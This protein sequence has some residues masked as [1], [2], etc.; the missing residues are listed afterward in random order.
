MLMVHIQARTTVFFK[1]RLV[2]LSSTSNIEDSLNFTPSAKL[3][4]D[5]VLIDLQRGKTLTLL[6]RSS[7]LTSPNTDKKKREQ[8]KDVEDVAFAI[9]YKQILQWDPKF[10][11]CSNFQRIT[12]IFCVAMCG[13]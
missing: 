4:C 11:L 2:S 12:A 1:E 9:F 7:L 8:I 6:F 5:V 10:S 13:C 3:I